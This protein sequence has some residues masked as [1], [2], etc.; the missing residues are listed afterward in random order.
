MVSRLKLLGAGD[1]TKLYITQNIGAIFKISLFLSNK[2]DSCVKINYLQ[3][4]TCTAANRYFDCV[5]SMQE[6]LSGIQKLELRDERSV[7]WD[8]LQSSGKSLRRKS[9]YFRRL[10]SHPKEATPGSTCILFC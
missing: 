1:N 6:I 2:E 7:L 5:E 3:E 10:E 9:K 4:F 8:S